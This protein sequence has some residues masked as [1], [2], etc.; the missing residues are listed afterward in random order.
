[1]S[2]RGS[3]GKLGIIDEPLKGAQ[4]SP[5]C[6]RIS[7][8]KDHVL[9]RWFFIVFSSAFG[10]G[11]VRQ[12]INQTTIE[13]IKSTVFNKS[14]LQL[15]PFAEQNRIVAEVDRRLSVIDEMEATVDANLKRAERL[16]QSI[17]KRA[18]EGKLVPQDPNDEP[19]S[20]LLERIQTEREKS[21]VHSDGRSGAAALKG[22]SRQRKL[23]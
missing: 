12:Q 2:V 15:P 13:T 11:N 14:P 3:V 6:I 22:R 7:L 8:L 18:F 23:W 19:A 1:M 21:V 5:N 4:V 10:F 9:P 16:R 20:V 17:L